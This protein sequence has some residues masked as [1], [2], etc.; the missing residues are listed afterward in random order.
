MILSGGKIA[1]VHTVLHELVEVGIG[2]LGISIQRAV[3]GDRVAV[4]GGELSEIRETVRAA[5]E[6]SPD[7]FGL[8]NTEG[9]WM[10]QTGVLKQALGFV[11]S[12]M[13]WG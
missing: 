11:T 5:I 7:G 10:H 3:T 2:T 13:F 6:I 12:I 4:G 1:G 8:H 9:K